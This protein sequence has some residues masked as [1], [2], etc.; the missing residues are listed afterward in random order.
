MIKT[1][2]ANS[3]SV[4]ARRDVRDIRGAGREESSSI[5]FDRPRRRSAAWRRPAH[6]P[7]GYTS[8]SRGH[9]V[10]QRRS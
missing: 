1:T 4:K 8:A 3:M 6:T 10:L 7:V 2:T 9:V 5:G